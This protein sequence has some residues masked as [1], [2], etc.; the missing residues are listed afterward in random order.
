MSHAGGSYEEHDGHH[1]LD[2]KPQ[3]DVFHR[4]F[5]L[6]RPNRELA[7]KVS[8]AKFGNEVYRANR[9]ANQ[10]TQQQTHA[11]Q[12]SGN[13]GA[14]AAPFATFEAGYEQ[15]AGQPARVYHARKKPQEQFT[16]KIGAEGTFDP[17]VYAANISANQQQHATNINRNTVGS[18]N[19]LANQK[20]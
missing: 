1:G 19:I 20:L 17:R 16:G 4:D 10:H 13:P 6:I 15:D 7:D 12:Y 11:K 2:S 8:A 3:E 14:G 18:G 9:L 5:H